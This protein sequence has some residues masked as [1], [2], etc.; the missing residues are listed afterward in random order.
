MRVPQLQNK[1]I[2]ITKKQGG[3]SKGYEEEEEEVQ[4]WVNEVVVEAEV[5]ESVYLE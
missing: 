4:E 3:P 5:Q 2:K 1:K